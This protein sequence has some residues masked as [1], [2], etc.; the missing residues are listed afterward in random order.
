MTQGGVRSLCSKKKRRPRAK[1]TQVFAVCVRER[2]HSVSERERERER[3]A[4]FLGLVFPGEGD[5]ALGLR[6][7]DDAPPAS[8]GQNR[9]TD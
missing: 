8:L 3:A 7:S 9:N 4:M 2:R 6:H 5:A 1:F